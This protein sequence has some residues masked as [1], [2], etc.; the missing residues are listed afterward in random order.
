MAWIVAVPPS[1]RHSHER[2][3][4]CFQ[5]GKRHRSAGIF[6]TRQRA[7]AEQRA[8]ER[9][10]RQAPPVPAELDLKKARTLFGEYV[11][12]KWWPAWKDQHP[13]SEYGTRKKV[14]KRILPT[15]GDLP[16]GELDPSTIGAWK[17][18]MVA[19]RL[20]PQTVNTYLSLL[21]TSLNAAVD[22][23][24]LARSPLVRKS[25]AGRAAATRNQPVA[26]REVWLTRTQLDRLA[27]AIKPRYRAL[28]LV[29]ALTGMRWGE[30]AALRWDDLR[31]D[32]SLHDG[33]VSGPGRVRI[34]R[35]LSD[36]HRSGRGVEKGPK[37]EAGIRTI[38]LDQETVDVLRAHRELVGG[39]AFARIFTTTGG[40]RGDG[41]TLSSSNFARV[42][43]RALRKAELA[44]LWPEYGGLRFHDLRHTHATWLIAQ[45]VP[46]IAVA[47]RL[48]HA[49]AVVTMMVYAHVDKL[50]D[51]GLL[52]TDEL[53]LA[54]RWQLEDD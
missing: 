31:L 18:A 37:T 3:Q 25:G 41:G 15:F 14:E 29:A 2:Y 26:R 24:Y 46:M 9:G 52:T 38:A 47:G 21:G 28:V 27:E 12:A 34:A 44:H 32:A 8:L 11:T 42:W 19:E 1:P 6:L 35:A 50:V 43:K 48:G 36:P 45:R 53:G 30:L 51:R 20:S 49:N 4:V 39:G 7:L 23:D 22:D 33:A 17:A 40:S 5:D 10:Q 13:T 54:G 16:L